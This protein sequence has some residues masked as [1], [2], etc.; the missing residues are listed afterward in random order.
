MGT[1]LRG[2]SD[3]KLLFLG[4]LH[5]K[6]KVRLIFHSKD[7]HRQTIRLF[8]VDQIHIMDFIQI[9]FDISFYNMSNWSYCI[10]RFGYQPVERVL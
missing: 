10:K 9:R 6:K 4:A 1:I 5:D 2:K 3:C 7:D 8:G